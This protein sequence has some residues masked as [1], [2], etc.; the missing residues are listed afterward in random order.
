MA[1]IREGS[2]KEYTTPYE[3][4]LNLYPDQFV[5][6]KKKEQDSWMKI[7][8]DY[9]YTVGL[10]QYNASRKAIVRNYGLLK[11]QLTPEDFYEEGPIQ[12][13]VDELIQD[14][15]LPKYV[16]HYPIINP[17]V[18]GLVGEK[19]KRPDVSRPKAMDD[20]SK[21]EELQYYTQMYQQL[22]Y[23]K[24]KE[25]ILK[26]QLSKGIDLSNMEEFEQ[27]V[28]ELTQ[29]K[30]K[31]YMTSYTSTAEKWANLMISAL[32][33]EFNLKELFE[34]GF[35]DM[36][37]CN[38]QYYHIYETKS[39]T[40]FTI[41]TLNAKNVWFL[42]TPDKKYT[43]DA[44]AAGVI[45]I[46]E[47][48]EIIN[49]Y[50]LPKDEIDHLRNYAMQ[51][52]FPYAKESNL[53]KSNHGGSGADSIQYN[54]YDPL[55]LE[56][57]TQMEARLQAENMQSLDSFLGNS[58]PN[59]GTFGN[60]F[61]VTT[62][63]WESKK[64]IGLLTYIDNDGIEQTQY[65]DED[66]TEGDHPQ[67]INIEW[68]YIN[69]WYKGLK[70]GDD[71]YHVKPLE[72][73]D[74]CPI[75]GVVFEIKNT[76]SKSLVDMMKPLQI[77]YNICMNQI[78]RF[79]EKEKGK[80]FI[81]NKRYIPLLKDADYQDSEEI[82]LR[83][84]EEEGIIFMD[85]SPEN[86]K[87]PSSFNQMTVI[88]LSLDTQIRGRLELALALK[89]ECWELVGVTQA[90]IGNVLASQTATGT[91][92]ELTQSYAQ[93]EPYFVQQE[94]IENQV[95]Q[96]ILDVAM[97]IEGNKP[98]STVNYVDN[99]GTNRFIT[100]QTATDLKNRDIKLFITSRSEDQQ[101]F[102]ELKQL[103]QAM[104]QNGASIYDVSVL[105]TTNSVRQ[106]KDIFKKLA[107]KQDEM[108][109]QQ[110]QVAAQQ[111]EIMQQ[112]IQ[113]DLQ[114]KEKEHQDNL[115]VKIYEVDTKAN[116]E[117]TKARIQE[118]IK[119]AEGAGGNDPDMLSI[120]SEYNKEQKD[121]FERDLKTLQA[122]MDRKQAELQNLK[123][124]EELKLKN[125]KMD[126]E[127]RGIQSREKMHR[128]DLKIKKAQLNKPKT[129]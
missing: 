44:Y 102:K 64:L 74:Y 104:L 12:S 129:K 54:T 117:L 36:L 35:R 119:L 97:Y 95:L 2:I 121:I 110:Q 29:E 6:K 59:V 77:L 27:Q 71:I 78:Y 106:M 3:V 53:I 24:A 45:E 124:A 15:E 56:A 126:L 57:R 66:Y 11:G 125:R 101:I 34:E 73:L 50:D 49:K 127:E 87:T 7:N 108:N 16:Q 40:G 84:M 42:T 23:Q 20:E 92:T 60:R 120:I 81:F 48:S 38:K 51:A 80:Q 32:K 65:V 68:G 17:P 43:R 99:E 39:K 107:E 96:A 19:S 90:R 13:F 63:Y 79:L 26:Q 55:V 105:Y 89:R 88:D 61:V 112:K 21:S 72:I 25:K 18:N 69:V 70:I 67:E 75:I 28:E 116:V 14:V 100:I 91:N 114:Q 22:V 128:E 82:W 5:S 31:E 10:S 122:D 85:D 98:E 8:M 83:Q 123:D 118:K 86:V 9:F 37:I 47:L 46:M 113:A 115:K 93:T 41:D 52:F 111:N 62:A 1:I 58:A 33:V 109:Q 4:M 76:I 30:I 103:S 94:Y